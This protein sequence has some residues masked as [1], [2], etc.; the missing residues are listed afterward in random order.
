MTSV[1]ATNIRRIITLLG[2]I[3]LL[4]A[5]FAMPAVAMADRNASVTYLAD[6]KDYI[7]E[8]KI[9]DAIVQLKNALQADPNNIEARV[10]LA[11]LY[12]R[13]NNGPSAE[14]EIKAAMDRGKLHGKLQDKLA[15]AYLLQGKYEEVINELPPDGAPA[16]VRPGLLCARAEAYYDLGK[17]KA[18]ISAYQAAEALIP[19]DTRPKIGLARA[20]IRVGDLRSAE[21][22]ADAA[23]QIAPNSADAIVAK[24]Q[25]LQ[26]EGDLTGAVAK[27]DAALAIKPDDIT[28]LISRA[29]AL[30]DTKQY[31]KAMPDI[32]AARKTDPLL[33]SAAYLNALVDA[34]KGDFRKAHEVLQEADPILRDYTP[35][36]YL[37]GAVAYARGAYEEAIVDLKS[38]IGTE[39]NNISAARML[40]AALLQTGD[41]E[42]AISVL[43][44]IAPKA[45]NDE[46]IRAILGSAYMAKKQ[47]RS[48]VIQ[49]QRAVE[50]APD[51]GSLRT[52][53]VVAKMA[54]G[55]D[56][57]ALQALPDA[58][59]KDPD[60]STA[61][62]TLAASE[63]RNKNFDA[64]LAIGRLLHAKDPTKPIG[65]AI[66]AAGLW[67][68]GDLKG[69]REHYDR[70]LKV[71]PKYQPASL[72]LARLD[73]QQKD[74]DAAGKRYRSLLKDDPKD[75]QALMGL[76][77]LAYAQGDTEAQD[78]W[79][80]RAI[81]TNPAAAGPQLELIRRHA[82]A[83]EMDRALLEANE[84]VRNHPQDAKALQILTEIQLKVRDP[85]AA[86]TTAS[87]LVDV[88]PS[89]P[90]GYVLKARA[91]VAVSNMDDAE[92]TLRHGLEI[93]PHDA[94]L[95]GE[96]VRLD[97]RLK[98][99]D[100]ALQAAQAFQQQV[101]GAAG[102]QLVGDVEL[103]TG[104][105]DAAIEAFKSA[106]AK[107]PSA[108]LA[109]RL[110]TAYK[111]KGDPAAGIAAVKTWLAGHPKDYAMRG[112]LAA[113]E[114][115]LGQTAAAQK[116]FEALYAEKP[117]DP[118][119]LNNLAWI[120]NQNNDARALEMARKA[121]AADKNSAQVLDTLGW[122]SLT[123]ESPQSGLD[124]LRMASAMSPDAAQ[125]RYHLAVALTKTGHGAEAKTILT[126]LLADDAHFAER[127]DAKQ[128]LTKLGG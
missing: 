21:V 16:D 78:R 89:L 9:D 43:E 29:V 75:V 32:L 64:V 95:N 10:Q 36:V 86:I 66:V 58:L 96:L 17:P 70:A 37:S 105:P 103:A 12:V 112:V 100:D 107:Q 26:A 48:A 54:V 63:L 50:I 23:L 76:Y 6:A 69:A 127:G 109:S 121:Y 3:A 35:A 123:S 33:P 84:L 60:A 56:E 15:E 22:N 67:G 45:A 92:T 42:S 124:Y 25:V 28:G 88:A 30:V 108:D 83:G 125:I 99:Y 91:Q 98:R 116:G 19:N 47:Y 59:A 14:K 115:D 102:D 71:D 27:Y 53:L 117:T 80:T 44:P 106:Y 40:A 62:G 79:L 97:M 11:G 7:A 104:Q 24:G 46:R 87:Q 8:G 110:N 111:L 94:T 101:P 126:S 65:E 128:L 5:A 55:D 34:R 51:N 73:A 122:I 118:I 90:R 13:R 52:K 77:W 1:G 114:L 113:A 57:G 93:A 49:F 2:L 38:Y 85:I 41:A 120:Y 39:P 18:A 68:K 20:Y 119:V 82:V 72:A 4:G 31:D 74:A 81:E 61:A